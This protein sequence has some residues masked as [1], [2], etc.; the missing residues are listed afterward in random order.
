MTIRNSS[1]GLANASGT[2][3]STGASQPLS[4]P[5]QLTASAQGVQV[6]GNTRLDMTKHG[7][8]PPVVMLGMLKVGPQIRIAFKGLLVH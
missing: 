3:T 6:E 1:S 8:E 5:V 4:F 7:I 2:M